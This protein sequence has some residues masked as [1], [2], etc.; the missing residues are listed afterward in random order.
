MNQ[1][2]LILT[3]T[4][5]SVGFIHTL[6][7]PDHYIPFIAMSKARNW[8]KIKTFWVTGICG[9]G[10]VFSSIILGAVGIALGIAVNSLTEIEAT[11]G[12]IAAWFLIAFGFV[13]FIWGI[14]RL[15]K[16]KPHSHIHSH[17]NG[18]LHKHTH[19]HKEGHVHVHD[20]KSKKNITPWILFTI[21]IFGPCEP[22]IP[23]LMYPAARENTFGLIIVTF[24]FAIITIGTMLGIVF[25]SLYGMSFLPLHKFEKYTHPIAGGV[26]F[27]SGFAIILFGL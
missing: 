8:S 1:E 27:I 17:S 24:V 22:L 16:N 20:E 6:L 23:I 3:L 13:Y 2:L 10:H 18:N 5:A 19:M 26:I 14:H 7:G 21:F 4:A 15:I 11:R 12:S 9:V 25:S